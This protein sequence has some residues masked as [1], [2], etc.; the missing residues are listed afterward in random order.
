M[1]PPPIIGNGVAGAIADV[2]MN[3]STL[4]SL[5]LSGNLIDDE[6]AEMLAKALEVNTVLT[7][8]D[9]SANRIRDLGVWRFSEA[10]RANAT[11]TSLNLNSNLISSDA[12]IHVVQA[13]LS[14]SSIIECKI[15]KYDQFRNVTADGYGWRFDRIVVRDPSIQKATRV[16]TTRN[17]HNARQRRCTL[18]AMLINAIGLQNLTKLTDAR[19]KASRS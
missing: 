19:A 5:N 7:H 10:I 1:H 14:N 12:A 15:F 8:L 4:A 9:L 17:A 2:L 11:L 6:G 13:L 18:E 3:S 16:I